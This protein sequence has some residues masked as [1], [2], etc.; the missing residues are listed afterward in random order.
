MQVK[1]TPRKAI[2]LHVVA[3]KTRGAGLYGGKLPNMSLSLFDWKNLSAMHDLLE[4]LNSFE[5]HHTQFVHIRYQDL[6][7]QSNS[8]I[9]MKYRRRA[10]GTVDLENAVVR[11]IIVVYRHYSD[12]N[13]HLRLDQKS[14][15]AEIRALRYESGWPMVA[16]VQFMRVHDAI[17]KLK[18]SG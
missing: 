6:A 7:P 14:L 11:R 9:L 16:R 1:S 13:G 2:T 4:F 12:C 10:D 15:R 5:F 3:N 8:S 18:K 17:Q